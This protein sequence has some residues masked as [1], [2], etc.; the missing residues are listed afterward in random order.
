MVK[1]SLSRRMQKCLVILVAAATTIIDVSGFT[2]Q[3]QPLIQ[4]R[5]K[6]G[7]LIPRSDLVA[8]KQISITKTFMT[9]S[10]TNSDNSLHKV[11]EDDDTAIPFVEV[12]NS[13]FIEC[14]ADSIAIVNG[15]EYT[16]G[17]PC[18]NAVALCY[19]DDDEQ[20]IPIEMDE[21]LMDEIFALAASIV[22]EEFGEELALERTPQTL[23]LVGELEEGEGD[24]EDEDEDDFIDE[25]EEDVEILLSFEHEGTEYCLV[26]LLDPIF[27][28]GKTIAED[29][30]RVQLLTPKE[31]D[32]V[33]P[34][35]EEMFLSA[36]EDTLTS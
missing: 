6:T 10:Q 36:Q 11:P 33:M 16:I 27:L 24:E 23:T 4:S 22:E 18:D 30:Q 15:V 2:L 1:V 29:D 20:L 21:D 8:S 17:S 28:V 14:Y 34:V 35:L 32:E 19:F 31:S 5:W 12:D 9:M 3:P 7:G 26:K 13:S 25:D